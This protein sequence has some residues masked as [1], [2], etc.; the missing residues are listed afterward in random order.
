[1]GLCV[2]DVQEQS[3]SIPM[4]GVRDEERH[5]DLGVRER[6]VADDPFLPVP[7][8]RLPILFEDESTPLLLYLPPSL[9]THVTIDYHTRP[10]KAIQR[11]RLSGRT[12]AF[13]WIVMFFIGIFIPGYSRLCQ[14]KI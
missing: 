3:L 6:A 1:M 10:S 12:E 5:A 8:R 11:N 2:Q 7:K 4:S 14:P 13:R 9:H